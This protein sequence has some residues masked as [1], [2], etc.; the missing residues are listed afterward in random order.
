MHAILIVRVLLMPDLSMQEIK[1][2]LL[3]STTAIVFSCNELCLP[4]NRQLHSITSYSH[5]TNR[6]WRVSGRT[7]DSQASSVIVD[8][9]WHRVANGPYFEALNRPEPQSQGEP[10]PSPPFIFEIRF[11]PKYKFSEWVKNCAAVYC[12]DVASGIWFYHIA[13]NLTKH[14]FK[15]LQI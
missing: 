14:W 15:Q 2:L 10:G 6:Q 13:I 9:G 8:S 4:S 11:R 7:R 1:T 5:V 3:Y 12:T